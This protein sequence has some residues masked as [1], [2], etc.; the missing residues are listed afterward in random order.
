[1]RG[2]IPQVF[3]ASQHAGLWCRY[4]RELLWHAFQSCEVAVI[5]VTMSQI[6]ELLVAI[7]QGN[8]ESKA[9]LMPLVYQELIG[10]ARAR[11][12]HERADH[13]LEATALVHEAYLRLFGK[14]EPHYDSRGH[15]FTAAA[16]AMRRIL[17]EHA[18][19]KKTL[20]SGGA[21]ARATWTDDLP[22]IHCPCDNFDDL[23]SL[24]EALDRLAKQ[25]PEEANLVKLLYFAGLNLDEAA[26]VMG[27]SRTTTFRRWKFARA[28]LYAA[29]SGDDCSV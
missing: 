19:K 28:W 22:E 26:K 23:L 3:L 6:T 29:I 11:M 25:M 16:E 15:F 5:V 17:I 2:Q 21:W 24:D 27:T 1:M 4:A 12:A 14:E 18:R 9:E 8:S 13:T 20:K 7:G 10:I